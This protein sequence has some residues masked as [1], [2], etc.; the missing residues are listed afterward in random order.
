[1]GFAAALLERTK[2]LSLDWHIELIMTSDLVRSMPR[3]LSE[4]FSAL[5]LYLGCVSFAPNSIASGPG[6]LVRG[7]GRVRVMARAAAAL[8]RRDPW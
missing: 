5:C 7:R 8:P 2:W 1:M 4:T 6:Y 3:A